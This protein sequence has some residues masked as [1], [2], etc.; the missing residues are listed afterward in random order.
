MN[1]PDFPRLTNLE[2]SPVP[3]PPRPSSG[4]SFDEKMLNQSPIVPSLS[5]TQLRVEK[6]AVLKLGSPRESSQPLAKRRTAVTKPYHIIDSAKQRR[7]SPDDLTRPLSQNTQLMLP[8]VELIEQWRGAVDVAGRTAMQAVLERSAQQVTG[9]ELSQ[10]GKKRGWR[11]SPSGMKAIGP[12]RRQVCARASRSVSRSTAWACRR[13]SIVAWRQ[14]TS[15]K[16]ATPACVNGRG[17]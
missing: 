5:R 8:L 7:V 10:P 9:G 3:Q 15:S 6:A 2:R 12:Q 13:R 16:V 17:E 11:S 14:P 4:S 1:V